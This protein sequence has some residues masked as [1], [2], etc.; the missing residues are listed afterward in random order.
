[1]KEAT[2]KKME[3][4]LRDHFHNSNKNHRKFSE[5]STCVFEEKVRV[6]ASIDG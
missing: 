4:Q 3:L 5:N 6:T 1:M 2:E